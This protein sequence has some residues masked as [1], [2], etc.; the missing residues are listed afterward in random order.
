MR[1]AYL[2]QSYPP[3]I[4]GAAFFARDLAEAMARR[5]HQVLVIAASD[6][7]YPYLDQKENLAVLRLRSF[8]N[9]MR[10]GQR[11]LLY[12]R[13]DVMKALRE[14]QPDVIHMHEPL[15]MGLLGLEYGKR[16]NIPTTL[17]LHQLP[18]FVASY[19]P[20]RIRPSVEAV[21]WTYAR[22]LLKRFT[23]IIAPTQTISTII[24]QMIGLDTNVIGYGLDLDIFHSSLSPDRESAARQKWN[25]P[26]GTP[27]ILHVGSLDTDKRVD[28]VILAAARVMR[29]SAA[30]LIVVGDGQQKKY[31]IQLCKNLGIAERVHFTGFV[32]TGQGLPEIYRMANLFVTAS[33]IETQGIVLLEAA[34]SELPL[35]AVRATCI[36]EIVHHEI[37]GYL[38]EPGDIHALAES[39]GRILK[40]PRLASAMGKQSRT[41][42]ERHDAQI[43]LEKHEKLYQQLSQD[44]YP[45]RQLLNLKTGK[46]V[47]PLHNFDK[48]KNTWFN[49][50]KE[51]R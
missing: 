44:L 6:K 3:M 47:S 10:V 28:R 34:A 49:I 13:R 32:L 27:L 40:N 26:P 23:S 7:K 2:S 42:A 22:W 19:L 38:A 29:E 39:M 24:M 18:W 41:L 1:I 8:F 51:R 20:E 45:A 35:V 12:P 31:L 43:K 5:G 11:F 21:L 25:L 4:S 37:N 30:H 9:P 15:Q 48:Q 36:P 14:F 50:E 46:P 16:A 17:T 33:E